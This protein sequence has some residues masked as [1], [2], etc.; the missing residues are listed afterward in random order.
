MWSSGTVPRVA[1][2]KPNQILISPIP[3]T[4][5]HV[6]TSLSVPQPQIT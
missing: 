5:A 6:W 1:W 4:E 2:R 3:V